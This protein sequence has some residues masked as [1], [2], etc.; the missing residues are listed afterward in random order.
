MGVLTAIELGVKVYE[1]G[2][3]F[4]RWLRGIEDERQ[5]G[6]SVPLPFS[7][8]E[9]QREQARQ[10]SHAAPSKPAP[11]RVDAGP[12]AQRGSR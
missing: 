7:A 3:A 5:N 10:A 4:Y 8:I 6:P 11:S 2:A 1:G 12:E 9:H